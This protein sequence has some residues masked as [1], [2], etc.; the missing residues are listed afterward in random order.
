VDTKLNVLK[1][2]VFRCSEKLSLCDDGVYYDYYDDGKYVPMPA[3]KKY[4]QVVA[5]L[6]SFVTSALYGDEQSASLHEI[7]I[8]GKSALFTS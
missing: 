2:G 3:I 6:H 8:P 4:G 5:W 7:F 1:L